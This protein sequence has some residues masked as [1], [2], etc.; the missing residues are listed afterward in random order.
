MT[1]SLQH[2][3]RR[4]V[5]S[6]FAHRITVCSLKNGQKTGNMMKNQYDPL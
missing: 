1:G 2:Y 3:K 5:V 6:H 4:Y